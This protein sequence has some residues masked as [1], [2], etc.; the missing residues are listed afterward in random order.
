MKLTLALVLLSS[1]LTIAAVGCKF[2]L[3][4]FDSHIGEIDAVTK[5]FDK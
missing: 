2:C 4:E 1:I 5:G 3:K